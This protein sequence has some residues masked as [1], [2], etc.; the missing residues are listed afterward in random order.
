[1]RFTGGEPLLRRGLERIVAATTALDP[2]T[3]ETSLTTN[4]LGLARRA[5]GLADAGLARV[6]ASL[7]T[8]RPEVF[9]AITHR[10][11]LHDVLAGLRAAADAGLGPVKVNAV[12]L[13]GVNA[14]EAPDLLA[15][16]LREGYEL[17]FIEQMPLDPHAAWDRSLMVDAAE[18]LAS[19]ATRFRLEP[20]PASVRGSAPAESWF[21]GEV[22][23]AAPTTAPPAS[24]SSPR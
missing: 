5:R 12:L 4:A 11:R 6:N 13:R 7:D 9:A 14:D 19:L 8:L 10:D 21:R 23:A 3:P 1:M 2:A 15:W 16:A 20:E 24:V 22:G 17:R 18:V